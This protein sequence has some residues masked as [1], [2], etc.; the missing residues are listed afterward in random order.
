[1]YVLEDVG[2]TEGDGQGANGF[3]LLVAAARLI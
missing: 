3:V 1:M 2:A